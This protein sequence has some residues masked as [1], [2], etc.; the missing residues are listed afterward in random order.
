[1]AF[2][3]GKDAL[4]T[5]SQQMQKST[6][7][8]GVGIHKRAYAS[9]KLDEVSDS[10][11]GCS[12]TIKQIESS[13]VRTSLHSGLMSKED[14]R[15]APKPVLESLTI[16]NDGGQDIS[17]AMLFQAD[18]TLKVFSRDDFDKIDVT[19]MTPRQ[20]VILEIGY[21]GESAEEIKGEITGFNFTIN[22]DLSYDV[23]IKVAGAGDGVVKT[24]F[25][26]LRDL[27]SNTYTDDES[28]ES[29]TSTDIFTNYVALAANST[30]P[31]PAQG[32]AVSRPDGFIGWVNHQ[33]ENTGLWS[34]IDAAS[35]NIVPYVTLGTVVHSINLNS[36]NVPPARKFDPYNQFKL[37][38]IDKNIFSSNPVECIFHF[39]SD[40]PNYGPKAD[41]RGLKAYSKLT[42]DKSGL[43]YIWFSIPFL[44]KL[45][46]DMQG[47]PG[48]EDAGK[49]VPTTQ[50]LKKLFDK[51]KQLSGG[52]LDIVLYNDPQ[53]CED[54]KFLILNRPT[55]S[56]KGSMT[57]LSMKN[58]YQKGIR[59]IS[60]TSN[61]DGELIALATAAAMDGEGA[62]HLNKVFTGCYKGVDSVS[63]GAQSVDFVDTLK[64]AKAAL[65]DNI[66]NDDVTTAQQALKSY[67]RNQNKKFVPSVSY[68]LECEVTCDGYIGAKYGQAFT[69]DRL[70][71]RLR[72]GNA[73]FVV[74]KIGQNFSGGDW[75]TNI[76]GLMMLDA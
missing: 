17:D 51:V 71:K 5:P 23:T 62:D 67:V 58:G 57:T 69:V 28:G 66:S 15:L 1:M 18:I 38:P 36:K 40:A 25:S 56:K 49:R 16:S 9:L 22:Q 32:R 11:V 41:Y 74:T 70:P 65:G 54:G 55:A 46:L 33:M 30:T 42:R 4:V 59:N 76:T 45:Y 52:Y 63:T 26:T 2:Q 31:S 19:F 44:Q 20:K 7:V 8:T 10:L 3:L 39:S 61:L 73:Y 48:E 35:D 12:D 37:P 14:G 64:K 43:D 75:T 27:S 21:V 29:V 24:D 68:G 13:T 72:S 50:Y 6:P 53:E 47:P 34:Y 60:L